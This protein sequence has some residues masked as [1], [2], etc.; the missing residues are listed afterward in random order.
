MTSGVV[1]AKAG[2]VPAFTAVRAVGAQPH[3]CGCTNIVTPP[4]LSTSMATTRLTAMLLF[5]RKS[6]ST[7]LLLSTL[8][9]RA[10][11]TLFLLSALL[12]AALADE[13][14]ADVDA[15]RKIGG[16]VRT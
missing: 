8:V 14:R 2:A 1:A 3:Y 10:T 6:V 12:R 16:A 5:F 9:S 4:P 11:S 15:C 7:V 13:A